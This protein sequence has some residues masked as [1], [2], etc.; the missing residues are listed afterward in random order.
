LLG[1]SW[2]AAVALGWAVDAPET[3]TGVV[4]VSGATMPWREGGDSAFTPI[5]TSRAAA[6]LGSALLG[7]YTAGD[8]GRG[9]AER[10]FRPQEPPEDYMAWLQPRLILRTGSFQANTEDIQ[11]LNG[12]L[13]PQ[14][15]RYPALDLSVRILHGAADE[16]TPAAIH[17]LELAEA[18][19]RAEASVFEGVGHM[20]HHARPE[21]VADAVAALAVKGGATMSPEG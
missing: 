12:A 9:A 2:G 1:H 11:R 16:T 14:A 5:V 8:D 13:I 15:A 19:P 3:A 6:A 10:I 18:L 20:L 21:A 7:A 4:V 17:A